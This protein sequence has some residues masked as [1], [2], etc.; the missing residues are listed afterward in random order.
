[1]RN[2]GAIITL[3]VII[4]LLCIYYLSFTLVSASI[5]NN[6][7]EFARDST[8]VVVQSKK[9]A[10]LDS[11]RDQPVYN[12]LFVDYTLEDINENKLNLGL[13]LQGGMHVVLEV[14]PIDIIKGLSGGS[15]D[16]DFQKALEMAQ[17]KQRNSQENFSELF[18]QSWREIAPDR[19]L[20]SVF[21]TA[22]NRERISSSS[23]DE[24]VMRMVRT[25]VESAIDRTFNIIRSRIDKF[26]TTSPNIQRLQ[27]T[28]RIQVE[29][30]GADDPERVRRM[31]QRVAKLEFWEVYDLNEI[32][33]VLQAM[34]GKLVQEQKLQAGNSGGS[35]ANGE[36]SLGDM[37]SAQDDEQQQAASDTDS[38]ADDLA[39]M[40]ESGDTSALDSLQ[41]TSVSPLF[42]LIR[43]QGGLVYSIR[44]TARI[45]SILNRED[46]QAMMRNLKFLWSNETR[47][48]DGAN[49][50]ELL[51]IKVT[52]GGRA[53]LT[54][55][56]I[57]DARQ[58]FDQAG[59]PSISMQM[60]SEGA[61]T[62]RRLTAENINKRIAV[63][64][65]NYVYSAPVV[66]NEIPNGNS[67][68][69]GS[70]AIEEAQDL[71]NILKAGS[72][73]ARARIVEEVI[74]GP[75]LGKEAQAQGIVSVVS[76]LAL[77]LVF[78]F[79]YYSKGGL[80][81]NVALVF[82]IFFIL[83]I[84]AQINAALTLPGIAGIVL[85]MGMSVD[86]NVLIFE[87]IREELRNGSSLLHAISRGY[88]KAYSSIID[89]N[90]TTL[91]TAIFLYIFGLGPVRGFATT[92]II[93]IL[94]SLFSAVLITR[95]IVTWMTKKG[96][97]SKLSFATPFTNSLFSNL[98]IDFVSR[99]KFAY[100][101]SGAVIGIGMILLV[102]EG[103]L[104]FGV[105]FKGG[106]SYVVQF[107]EPIPASELKVALTDDFEDKGTEVKTYGANNVLRV[108]TSY[109]VDDES[110]EGDIKVE[111]ALVNGVQ[112]FTKKQLVRDASSVDESSFAIVSSSKVGA[113]IADDIK[114]SSVEAIIFSLLGIFV[115]ILIRFKR[116]QYS[117][118]AVVALI[119]DVLV[120]V[121]A[122][123]IAR[124]FGKAFEVDQVFI[125][126][127]LTIIGYSINDTVIIFDRIRENLTE[128]PQ[129]SVEKTF[130]MS[131]N[132]TLSRTLITSG[133]TMLVVVILLLFGG[134]VLRGFS[135][136][137]FIGIM[138]GTY[139]SVF[140]AT[141]AVIDFQ[142]KKAA[143]AARIAKS[144]E[145][146][147]A[148]V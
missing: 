74:V 50:V 83:G 41:P 147:K 30:P 68:I 116:W 100:V 89:G 91:I 23:S 40:L 120:V 24:E 43:G 28:G 88:S 49:L 133:T 56:V 107:S 118:G 48:S 44:D 59:R 136:A 119:H 93:G 18:Y 26:G 34:D 146:A 148:K 143:K 12:L 29:L 142:K 77:V 86:A 69:T 102:F 52:R 7:T 105:D 129:S 92:L 70:F 137:L 8:G 101:L 124:L 38:V 131:L 6:A 145:K 62:W 138:V 112:D 15:E 5:N 134:E 64:L 98:N 76:G 1:M 20:N 78:M 45:N 79:A 103:G 36:D 144:K 3:T 87:R 81:A 61:K 71:A 31:L 111:Q 123:A 4:T 22:A 25:E 66:Q 65:D 53:P 84:L 117:L 82:N 51:P 57:T 109:L 113:T 141:P 55:E 121:S 17:Q 54:G 94:S 47:E 2:K 126:A 39:S 21:L 132:D 135:F 10:Y 16:P 106:R 110:E 75:T 96:D 27:G 95:V 140:V 104:N 90:L 14:S 37:L 33:P 125:A 114:N 11:I 32:Y 97:K 35:S 13:D 85:T 80:V 19:R 115:Y 67:Q 73:P 42:S 46:M 122:F 63:V 128:R 130:N 108:T 60:N 9:R 127:M 58:D 99:R 139:S 72:L